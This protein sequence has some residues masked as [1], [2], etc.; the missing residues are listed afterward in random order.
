[1]QGNRGTQQSGEGDADILCRYL[2]A[3]D[4]EDAVYWLKWS[5]DNAALAG[6]LWPE[7]AHLARNRLYFFVP[8]LMGLAAASGSG[9]SAE[10]QQQIDAALAARYLR[11]ARAQQELGDFEAAVELYRAGLEKAPDDQQLRDGLDESL[12]QLDTP[13][14]AD[15]GP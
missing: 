10:L 5:K 8:E 14:E 15:S 3:T 4:A 12:A 7:V 13:E 9:K 11:F 6:V 2:D 1:V